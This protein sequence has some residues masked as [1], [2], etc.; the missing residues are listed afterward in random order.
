MSRQS[1]KVKTMI[2][3]NNGIFTHINYQFPQVFD[4][5]QQQLDMLFIANYGMRSVA[6]IVRAIHEDGDTQLTDAELT[7]LGQLTHDYFKRKWD[8]LADVALIEYDPIHNYSDEYHEELTE[9]IEGNDTLTHNT[10]VTNNETLDIDRVV[11]DGGTERR[12]ETNTVLVTDGGEETRETEYGKRL[13]VTESVSKSETKDTDESVTRTDNLSE[14]AST[15]GNKSETR[16]DNLSEAVTGSKD[17]SDT[18]T[19]NLSESVSRLTDDTTT[20][21]DN[22]SESDTNAN[23]ANIFGFN[24][25]E[26]VGANSSDGIATKANTGTQTTVLDGEERIT[27]SDTGTQTHVIDEETSETKLNT[28]TQ[29]IAG[30]NSESVTKANTGTQQNVTDGTVAL[31]GSE[32]KTRSD[33]ESGTDVLTI[34]GGL[35]ESTSGSKESTI[36]GGLT[37]TTQDDQVTQ[38]TKRTT[39]TEAT[40]K[41]SERTRGRDF[42][43]LGN[44]GNL[45]TQ[46]LLKE[47]IELWRWNFIEQ[48]LSDVK[49]FLTIPMYVQEV[50]QLYQDEVNVINAQADQLLQLT[51]QVQSLCMYMKVASE[52]EKV[53]VDVLK[54]YIASADI[55][56]ESLVPQ[57]TLLQQ[58]LDKLAEELKK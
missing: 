51:N 15:T 24:S 53:S 54:A 38:G 10:T 58:A 50:K 17:A 28:G 7:Q 23:N 33:T 19:D 44:I 49:D 27:K 2:P 5:S 11:T 22:L 18:R 57:K 21:T 37:H 34:T 45:T 42:T 6:P 39:G 3:M 31:T 20:R 46:Q 4:I 13:G 1:M 35:T 55:V 8:R 47:E 32:Q 56:M 29:Q 14:S 30:I 41:S 52:Q 40:D 16:T 43:H 36:V 48:V 12:T 25:S 26:A 9:S